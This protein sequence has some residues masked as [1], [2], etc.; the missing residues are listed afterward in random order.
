MI[1]VTGAS[2]F[3]GKH[4]ARR[5]SAQ[6]EPVRALYHNNPPTETDKA[7]PNIQWQK[8]DLLDVFDVEEVMQGVTHIYH[9]AAIV[10][11]QPSG[12]QQMLHFNPESTANIVNQAIEQ[13][14]TKMVYVS[15]VAALGRS[16]AIQKEITEDEEWGESGYNSAYGISKYM[17]ETE[18]WRGIGEGLNAVIVNPGIILGEGD[19][20]EGSAEL[21]KVAFSEFPF[22]TKGINGWV[23]VQDVATILCELMRSEHEAERYIISAGNHSYHEIFT[24]MARALGK[25]PPHIH[26]NSFITSL[27]WRWGKLQ[28]M[29][30]K[31][32]LITK[33]TASN[34]HSTS[35]YNNKK[36]LS[37]LPS[38]T[39]TSI[40][41]TIQRMAKS[42]LNVHNIK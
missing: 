35:L 40:E 37:A 15:S 32:P 38:F 25:K 16:G 8:A 20:N 2:G 26:A 12:H 34:A 42:F 1:L 10:S 22:Y 6:G 5:L 39:Y 19:F 3:L 31:R 21:M 30:G 14:I 28:S 29:F 18:V 7:L 36:L 9:C 27:I 41:E 17:A 13:G 24:L 11:F 23:D 33:E 4:L